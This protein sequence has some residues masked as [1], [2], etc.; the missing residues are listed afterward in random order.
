ML[1]GQTFLLLGGNKMNSQSRNRPRGGLQ[2]RIIIT[3]GLIALA[4]SSSIGLYAY[5]SSKDALTDATRQRLTLIADART[6][7]VRAWFESLIQDLNAVA[8]SAA[9]RLTLTEVR[10]AYVASGDE[11]AQVKEHFSSSS[12]IQERLKLDGS[13]SQSLYGFRHLAVHSSFRAVLAK[14]GYAD[15]LIL[16]EDGEVI[17]STTKGADFATNVRKDKNSSLT[18]AFEAALKAEQGTPVFVDFS[19][20]APGGTEPSAFFAQALRAGARSP[21][22]NK[23]EG[24]LVV[25]VTTG[26]LD[27]MINSREGLGLTGQSYIIGQDGRLR[28]NWPLVSGM[29]ALQPAR[30]IAAAISTTSNS[31]LS[32]SDDNGELR[33][34]AVNAIDVLGTKLMVVTEQTAAEALAQVAVAGRGMLIATMAILACALALAVFTGMSIVRPITGLTQALRALAAGAQ[35]TEIAGRRRH[36]EI[37]DIARAVEAIR[38]LARSQAEARQKADEMDRMIHERQQKELLHNL[39]A[40]FEQ[41]VGSIVQSLGGAAQQL[42]ASAQ[43]MAVSAEH[44][45]SRSERGAT[46]TDAA[47]AS[48]RNVAVAAEQLDASIRAF[49][50]IVTRF[51]DTA[52]VADRH[53]GETTK[54]VSELSTSAERIGEVVSLIEAIANQTNLLALNAT[55]EAARAGEAGKG[56]A[57]VAAEVKGLASQTAKATVEI[58]SQI[59]TMRAMTAQVVTA[60]GTIEGT[61]REISTAVAHATTG[62][63]QQA[64]ATREIAVNAQNA[65]DRAQEVSATISDVRVAVVA[66]DQASSSVLSS[67]DDLVLQAGALNSNVQTF[68]RQVRAG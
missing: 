2:L 5:S 16:T 68:L 52:Q 59:D 26:L 49:S 61:I 9:V 54:I 40:E 64:D 36:D 18:N 47:S 28:S 44:A 15:L 51:G 37:G 29:T 31:S 1:F 27:R 55:I 8:E 62:V 19:P 43:G 48:V 56:F 58:A 34:A 24:V 41:Q 17:Y 66:T 33:F 23:I 32:Y 6:Q 30:A 35:E 11:L 45:R 20:Y 39:A 7:A 25:R 60:I 13:S 46:A 10:N 38:D 21:D 50:G 22:P 12:D 65:S 53:A 57:V 4:A 3:I 42:R 14:G 63:L 67:A